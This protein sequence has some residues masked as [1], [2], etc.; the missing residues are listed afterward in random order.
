M[1]LRR[2]RSPRPLVLLPGS[3]YTTHKY[4][5]NQSS[6]LTFPPSPTS[7]LAIP[8]TPLTP[9]PRLHLRTLHSDLASP[10]ISP[11]YLASAPSLPY[12]WIWR[13]HMCGSIYRLGITR[14]CLHDGHFFCSG[15]PP[16]FP[17]Q[18]DSPDSDDEGAHS[19]STDSSRSSSSSDILLTKERQSR[20]ARRKREKSRRAV[21][22]NAEFDYSG[23]AQYNA[24]RRCIKI[25]KF[26]KV[27]SLRRQTSSSFHTEEEAEVEQIEWKERKDCWSDCE[28]P[29]ECHNTRLQEELERQRI[30][31]LFVERNFTSNMDVESSTDEEGEEKWGFQG[32]LMGIEE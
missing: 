15:P 11:Q 17:L 5:P 30:Q 26:E 12:P 21:G 24:W 3:K 23:W 32:K 7:L 28:F 10:P 14:R 31:E 22:C 25:Y 27:Q 4:T 19:N 9:P 13:C 20:N 2:P 1:P 18:P 6:Y 29:S 8:R 16:P